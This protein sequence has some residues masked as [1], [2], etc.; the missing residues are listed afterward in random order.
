MPL[1]LNELK[2]L[3]NIAEELTDEKLASIGRRVIEGYETDEESR[4]E[5]QELADKAM[6]IAKQTI[7][8]KNFPFPN[9]ANVKYPLITQAAID[10]A[11]RTYP[12]VIQNDKVAKAKILGKDPD[13]KKAE[14]AQRVVEYF[15]YQLIHSSDEWEESVDKLLHIL[16]VVGTVFKKT[17]YDTVKKKAI[18]EVCSPASIVVNHHSKSL[19][20][21][22][23]IT[24]VMSFQRNDI[25]SRVRSGIF[26]DCD[27]DCM[28]DELETD[29]FNTEL[30][31]QHCLLDLDNDGYEEPYIVTVHKDSGKVLRI[32]A[33]FGKI[34]K[35]DKDEVISI[36]PEQ[37]FTDFHFI[38]SPDGGFYSVGLGILLYPL[39][40]AINSLIN[41]LLDAGTLNNNQGGFLGKGLRIKNG[42]ISLKLNEWKVLD[43]ASGTD[44]ARNIVPLPTKEPSPTLFQ[45]LG[46]LIQVGKDLVSANDVLQG[47]GQTQN[48][49]PNSIFQLV[50]QGLKVFNAI[51]KRLYRS[52]RKELKKLY[53]INRAH[54]T[55]REYRNVLDDEMADVKIDFAN[56]DMDIVPVADPSMATDIQRLAK[57]Q[58]IMS[59]PTINPAE[60]TKKY[61]QAMQISEEEIAKLVPEPD[62]NAPP[63]PEQMKVMSEVELNQA[64]TRE[65][66]AELQLRP[67]ELIQKSKDSDIREIDAMTRAQESKVRQAKMINDAQNNTKKEQRTTEAAAYEALLKEEEL[68]V[69]YSAGRPKE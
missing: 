48:V 35:N 14:R 50:E 20:E 69:K 13:N 68:A 11:S 25:I 2:K 44:I 3:S 45:L 39:N 15:S 29:G 5:W 28:F 22:P 34:A 53:N 21:A 54:L 16:P 42:N 59:L 10:F 41:Q 6:S 19:E 32:A 65:I 57:A 33:R 49:S 55:N 62:P 9:S 47:K 4:A 30:L 26:L 60:A 27:I 58:S 63:A 46:L 43:A 36:E 38:K 8:T 17:H 67:H 61:L 40:S 64:K 66:L 7:E 51:F 37:Y 31:E 12:E 1:D 18:S 24:H 56:D 52:F 23:R